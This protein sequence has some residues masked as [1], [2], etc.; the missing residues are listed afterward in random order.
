[1]TSEEGYIRNQAELAL[2][3][4]RRKQKEK[5]ATYGP[6]GKFI[7]PDT[8][9]TLAPLLERRWLDAQASDAFSSNPKFVSRSTFFE[10]EKIKFMTWNV[11]ILFEVLKLLGPELIRS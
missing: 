2:T 7:A 10:A 5:N 8:T 6:E 11:S 3:A 1:M 9:H 4:E